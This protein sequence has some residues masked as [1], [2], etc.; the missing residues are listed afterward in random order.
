MKYVSLENTRV[1]NP[2]FING[3]GGTGK[4][5]VYKCLINNCIEMGYDIIPVAWT[6]AEMLL[7]GGRTVHSRFKLP[8]ILTD[9]CFIIKG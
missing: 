7:L 9:T 4:T 6:R 5:F 1:P 3:P 2:Y 8:L